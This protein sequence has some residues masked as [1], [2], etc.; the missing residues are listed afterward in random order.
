MAKRA[1]PDEKPYRPLLNPDVVSA[2]LNEVVPGGGNE[3]VTVAPMRLTVPSRSEAAPRADLSVAK[4]A[5]RAADPRRPVSESEPLFEKFDQEKR[6]LFTRSESQAIDRLVTALATRVNAQV[7][8]SHVIRALVSLLLHA[9]GDLDRRAGEAGFLTRPPNG[10]AQAL[11]KFEREIAQI[12]ASALRD[13]GP[14][15]AN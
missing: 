2:V 15:R 8:V 13:A 3:A 10:N 12:I 6:I 1:A 7:K 5:T 14:I 4:I 9:E 11:Q